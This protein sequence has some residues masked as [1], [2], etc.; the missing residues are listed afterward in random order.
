MDR[1]PIGYAMGAT[2][3]QLL[4]I[5]TEDDITI[6]DATAGS[7][8]SRQSVVRASPLGGLLQ[9]RSAAVSS[10]VTSGLVS[11]VRSRHGVDDNDDGSRWQLFKRDDLDTGFLIK[12]GH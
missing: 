11:M 2:G 1:G 8:S 5:L 12:L 6:L 4:K 7:I 9:R 3:A 10:L